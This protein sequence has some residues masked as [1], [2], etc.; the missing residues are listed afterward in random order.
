MKKTLK[1][2]VKGIFP[3]KLINMLIYDE[4]S[5]IE[6]KYHDKYEYSK[7]SFSQ[8]GEDLILDRFFEDKNDG[9]FIDIG[10]HHP[11]RFSNT[12]KFYQKGWTGINIDPMPGIM[13][14]FSI[15]RPKD[16]N[17]ELGIS[18]TEGTLEY[19]I[20]NETALNTFDKIEADAKNNIPGY[21]IVEKKSIN[22]STLKNILDTYLP[23]NKMI[24]FI[25]IDVE[26]LDIDVLYSNDWDKYLPT[27]ILIEELKDSV[28]SIIKQ[29]KIY[30]FLKTKNYYLLARTYNTSIYKHGHNT[31]YAN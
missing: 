19:N 2:I 7:I 23:K 12:Y 24:D 1:N 28:D 16:I 14:V 18:N 27:I 3:N 10:A 6:K 15:E 8:E 20:F 21:N 17:L 25:S 22:V 11:R 9:F 30:S 5:L 13:N 4:V 29:S 31:E 26:G